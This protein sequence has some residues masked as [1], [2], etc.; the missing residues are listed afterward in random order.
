[1]EQHWKS[2][3]LL[4]N[5]GQGRFCDLQQPTAG[6][7]LQAHSTTNHTHGG[8]AEVFLTAVVDDFRVTGG[9]SI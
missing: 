7:T 8:V 4:A 6:K 5:A 1:V 9:D 3:M 2:G